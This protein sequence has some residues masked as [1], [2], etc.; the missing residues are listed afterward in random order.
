MF[1]NIEEEVVGVILDSCGGEL[2]LAIDRM[3]EM[4]AG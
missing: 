2:G 3:L 4:A 1:P